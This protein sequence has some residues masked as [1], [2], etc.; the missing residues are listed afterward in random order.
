MNSVTLKS[1][2]KC[3]ECGARLK[4][5]RTGN[6]FLLWCVEFTCASY[7][8]NAGTMGRTEEEAY[9]LLQTAVD[10]EMENL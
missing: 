5:E 8:A 7:A 9:Q 3:P 1:K 2:L 6:V 10:C 4:L